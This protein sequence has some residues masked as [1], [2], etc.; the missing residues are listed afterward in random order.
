[1]C[2][3]TF[4][5]SLLS[6][7]MSYL[8]FFNGTD[9]FVCVK[10]QFFQNVISI[11]LFYISHFLWADI[12]ACL[13]H[14]FI[15]WNFLFDYILHQL[16]CSWSDVCLFFLFMNPLFQSNAQHPNKSHPKTYQLPFYHSKTNQTKTNAKTN[17]HSLIY[18]RL[19]QLR[20]YI[21]HQ[22]NFIIQTNYI[23]AIASTR[24][25]PSII[26]IVHPKQKFTN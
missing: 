19:Y 7:A 14:Q 8:S 25:P 21:H 24:H 4:Y 18:H 22:P 20:T 16:F 6:E 11:I 12:C 13:W 2:N 10:H 23:T 9:V 17:I 5:I 3:L 26:Y 1:M 15:E